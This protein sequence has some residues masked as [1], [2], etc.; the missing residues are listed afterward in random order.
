MINLIPK[1]E[2]KDV[3]M[4][5]RLRLGVVATLAVASLVISNLILL[6]P[7]YFLAAS[8]YNSIS[9]QLAAI[10]SK[11]GAV[12]QVKDAN[13]YIKSIN[14]KIDIFMQKG[15]A[16]PASPPQVILSILN[17]KGAEIKIQG[18]TY[19]GGVGQGRLVITG[20]AANRDSLAGFV[21][22]LKSDPAFAKV[23]LPISSYVKSTNIDFSIVVE[24]GVKK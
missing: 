5:Y 7:S 11:Q 9:A 16:V 21:E 14:K 13:A 3:L 20:N 4:E 24:R 6:A 22:K 18:F 10:E 15:V 2:K 19:D 1:K 8:K 23:D 17:I 12:V